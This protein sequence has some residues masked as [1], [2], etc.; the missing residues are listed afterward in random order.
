VRELASALPETEETIAL[1]LTASTFSLQLG[2]RLGTSDE[3]PAVLFGEAERLASRAGDVHLRALL[4]QVYGAVRGLGNGDVGDWARLERQAFA[5]AEQS[6]DAGLY[7]AVSLGTYGIFC[8]GEFREVVAICDR[9]IELA[10][11]DP[12][13][14]ASIYGG[15]P[16]A[17][18]LAQKGM[19]LGYLGQL[20]DARRLIE[21][22]TEVAREQ[23]D[24]EMAGFCHGF[25]NLLAYFRGEP[26]D[27]LD[28]ARQALEIAERIGS[29][30][31]RALA[32]LLLGLAERMRGEWQQ[33]ITALERSS[34]IAG[35]HRTNVEANGLRLALLGESY[36]GLGDVERARTLVEEGLTIAHTQ[37]HPPNE[38][39]CSLALA[40]VLLGSAGPDA[41]TEI[42]AALERVLELAKGTGAKPHVPLVR[43][44]RAEL[45][46]QSGNPDAYQRELRDAHRLFTEM[47]A[48]GHAKRLQAELAL[49]AS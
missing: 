44:V 7:L 20:E 14:G 13:V 11:G 28:H 27:A 22:G 4:L 47:G 1:A 19:C 21:Q 35:E 48:A 39:Y 8:A 45:A 18:C 41:R 42:E 5:L 17:W 3:D 12:T 9:A 37:E 43:V 23:G 2:W 31:S 25:A 24:T 29:S 15:C 30:F 46:R 36:L 33:A 26:E 32:W 49:A 40:E 16:Y 6:G 38:M 34:A 10:D